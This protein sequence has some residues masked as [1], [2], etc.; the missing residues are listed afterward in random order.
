[1]TAKRLSFLL[2]WAIFGSIL[3]L[4][5][6]LVS[7]L[8]NDEKRGL[9]SLNDS[10]TTP[11]Q[12]T[13]GVKNRHS[14]IVNE[15]EHEDGGSD[16]AESTDSGDNDDDDSADDNDDQATVEYD[17]T[18]LQHE[19]GD[20]KKRIP[21]WSRHG[22]SAGLQ[23]RLGQR[24][25]ASNPSTITK[26]PPNFTSPVAH[27]A[28]STCA[29]KNTTSNTCSISHC[30]DRNGTATDGALYH[31]PFGAVLRDNTIRGTPMAVSG[32]AQSGSGCALSRRHGFIYIHVLKSGGMTVKAFLKRA[33]CGGRTQM[34]CATGR[35]VLEIVNCGSAL[36]QYPEYFVF[37]FVRNPYSRL[38]SG[39]SMAILY[40]RR[41]QKEK[42]AP[43]VLAS[44]P[45]FALHK[46][47]RALAS[48]VSASHYIPQSMFLFDGNDCPVFDFLGRLE[49]FEKDFIEILKIIDSRELIHAFENG[50][51]Q[52]EES[53]AYGS[54]NLLLL[55][56]GLKGAYANAEVKLAVAREYERD[57]RLFG[58]N[59]TTI[60]AR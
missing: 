47:I 30:P 57:F 52:H 18:S 12:N 4:N 59:V 26:L 46:N 9:F 41:Q 34:P 25:D 5:L 17:N 60:P 13:L 7:Q 40:D 10:S 53:T 31:E 54:R 43:V 45:D 14:S 42:A 1:M 28:V 23:H 48:P 35:D 24:N 8:Q 38:Y 56:G 49:H 44:F 20:H 37:S 15:A 19:E 27:V 33:L 22:F 36:Q 29:F 55:Q 2:L 6:V 16:D 58:Y 21:V 32:E 39:Y 11:T 51:L 3:C 50:T